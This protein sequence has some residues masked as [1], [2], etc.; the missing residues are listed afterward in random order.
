MEKR[1]LIIGTYDTALEGLWTLSEQKLGLPE[2]KEEYVEVPGRNG[3]L[4]LSTVLTDGEPQY[5]NR[6]FEA[7]LE[8]SEG[9]RDE[10]NSRI[11][12]MVNLLDGLK[13][14]IVLPDDPMHYLYGRVRVEKLYSD[15]V[16]AAVK[17]TA[18]CEPWMYNI[19]ETQV[20]LEANATMQATTLYNKGRMPVIPNIK[21]VGG[22]VEI[23]FG[24][25]SWVISEGSYIIPEIFLK[26]GSYPIQY[27]GNGVV[28]LSYREAVIM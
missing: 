24:G 26:T 10:R 17:V 11:S 23:K 21:I 1:K 14:K 7:T 16:H 6:M 13:F 12:Y 19:A 27:K 9:T 15:M 22:P 3:A 25:H 20:T 4:D 2:I 8:S 18:T 5:S 28:L